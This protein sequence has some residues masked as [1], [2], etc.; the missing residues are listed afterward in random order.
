[1]NA[2][3]PKQVDRETRLDTTM[4]GPGNRLTYLYTLVNLSSADVDS[5]EL[6]AKLKSQIINGYKTLP[7]MAAF[8]K[9][10]VELHYH[11]RDKNGNVVATIVVSPKDF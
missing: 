5:T 10:Q 11:Y 9:R 2:G 3:L 6:T 7:E 1:M 8:R 4:A